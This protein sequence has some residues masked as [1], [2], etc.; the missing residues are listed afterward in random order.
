VPSFTVTFSKVTT[1]K[2]LF[3]RSPNA[4]HWRR[5]NVL[6]AVYFGV[7][8]TKEEGQAEYAPFILT[9]DTNVAIYSGDPV[10]QWIESLV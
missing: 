9:P 5:L 4:R 3:W 8:A 1:F 2:N 7:Y 10:D 6:N